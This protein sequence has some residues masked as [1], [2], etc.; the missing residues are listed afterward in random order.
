MGFPFS[1][2]LVILKS[3]KILFCLFGLVLT[4]VVYSQEESE[5]PFVLEASVGA[6]VTGYEERVSIAPVISD[7]DAAAGTLS[8]RVHSTSSFLQPYGEFRYTSSVTNVE[9]WRES[10][11]LVQ[12]NDLSYLAGDLRA[13]IRVPMKPGRNTQLIPRFGAVVTLEEFTRNDFFFLVQGATLFTTDRE[14]MESVLTAGPSVG[15]S[16]VLNLQ[17]SLSLKLDSEFAWLA[18]TE[19]DNDGFNVNIEGD[20]GWKWSSQLLLVKQLK[21]EG[22]RIGLSLTADFQ[23]IDGSVVNTTG[24]RL[25]YPD[26]TLER[27]FVEL[28]WS[29]SF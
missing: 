6:G 17:D 21:R 25:E 23:E 15:L 10:G 26:N 1:A 16:F 18:Y 13:G 22:R 14:V 27:V 9:K 5:H 4:C 24:R 29:A 20:G 7:W 2:F 19:A 12:E 11:V 3:M 8:L 28:I